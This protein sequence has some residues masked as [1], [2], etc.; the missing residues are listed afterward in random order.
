[1]PPGN[2]ATLFAGGSKFGCALLMA[3]LLLN[4]MAVVLQL[5][6]TRLGVGEGM[7]PLKP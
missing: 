4:V 5:L 7:L 6:C 1:M 3:A 2:W